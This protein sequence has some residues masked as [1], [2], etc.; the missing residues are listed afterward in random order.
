M[1]KVSVYD[2]S[3]ATV[4]REQGINNS[5]YKLNTGSLA[6]ELYFIT[7]QTPAGVKTDKFVVKK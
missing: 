3:E 7:V 2:A 1:E 6:Q 4:Y 5:E